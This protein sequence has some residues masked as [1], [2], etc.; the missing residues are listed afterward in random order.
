MIL[1]DTNVL[2]AYTVEDHERA[3]N[4]MEGADEIEVRISACYAITT[5]FSS[6]PG[7]FWAR[8]SPALTGSSSN[9]P[10]DWGQRFTP[11]ARY[12]NHKIPFLWRAM[13]YQSA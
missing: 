11:A 10:S 5:R 4:I 1:V 8:P 9:T 12:K 13:P 6:K 2:F 7:E 3:R